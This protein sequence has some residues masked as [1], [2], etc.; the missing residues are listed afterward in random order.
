[1]QTLLRM[2]IEFLGLPED[3][4]YAFWMLPNCILSPSCVIAHSPLHT[5]QFYSLKLCTLSYTLLICSLSFYDILFHTSKPSRRLFTINF[6]IIKPSMPSAPVSHGRY[7]STPPMPHTYFPFSIYL[8]TFSYMLEHWLY[9]LQ[10]F[11]LS[12]FFVLSI[13]VCCTPILPELV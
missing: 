5:M 6:L 7:F 10:L 13:S 1:M 4:L 9:V 11:A 12:S 2:L 3:H 8:C